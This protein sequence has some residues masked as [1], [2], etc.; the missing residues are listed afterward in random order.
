MPAL[1]LLLASSCFK[2]PHPSKLETGGEDACFVSE[3]NNAL[4]VA[5]G[6]GGW[7]RIPESNSSKYSNDLMFYSNQFSEL[8][9]PMEILEKAYDS[10][11]KSV[12]GSS[13]ATVAKLVGNQLH[14]A[15]VGDSGC[16]LFREFT[17]V[18]QTKPTLHGFNFPYQLGFMSS[19]VPANGTH[20]WITVE[21]GDVLVC[22][23]DGLW[24]NVYMREI[25]STLVAANSWGKDPAGFAAL[26]ARTLAEKAIKYGADR[27]RRTPFA[28][29]SHKHNK[30]W[31]GG[32][33][34]DSTVVVS[35]VCE[36]YESDL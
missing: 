28:D 32:K 1:A 14:I 11:N 12:I 33:L 5:D 27:D 4:G 19:T 24:D 7:V 21:G 29:E 3:S 15:N 23:S 20:D 36:N 26:A 25:E 10:I 13:T 2:I 8:E 16:A 30:E 35:M 18:Y 6:V 17:S 31:R 9:N 34:D 22:A